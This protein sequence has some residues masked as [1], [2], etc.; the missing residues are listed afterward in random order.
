MNNNMEKM[1]GNVSGKLGVD[2]STLKNAIQS[3]STETL[4]SA[5]SPDQAQMLNKLL[6]DKAATERLLQSEQIQKLIKQMSEGK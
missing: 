4:M 6:S 3:G 1:L 5:L 2:K